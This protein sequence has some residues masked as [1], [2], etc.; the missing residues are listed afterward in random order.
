M[1]CAVHPCALGQLVIGND[2]IASRGVGNLLCSRQGVLKVACVQVLVGNLNLCGG[3]DSDSRPAS[4]LSFD[5]ICRGQRLLDASGSNLRRDD[6]LQCC[7]SDL[8][9]LDGSHCQCVSKV[10]FLQMRPDQ[11]DFTS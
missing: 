1:P 7:V 2:L 3:Y 5:G 10:P 11:P 9:G 4:S 8:N 6:I